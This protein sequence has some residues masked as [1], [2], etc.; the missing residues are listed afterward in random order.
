M[1]TNPTERPLALCSTDSKFACSA[2]ADQKAAPVV[3]SRRARRGLAARLLPMLV[4]GALS[5]VALLS[6]APAFAQSKIAIVDV[7]RA[8]LE[9]EEGLRVQ[10]TLKKLFD[11]RQVELETKERAL[12]AEKQKLDKEMQPG[13]PPSDALQRRIEAWQRQVAELQ[14]TTLEYQREM[15]RQESEMIMPLQR[16][17]QKVLWELATKEGYDLILDRAAAPYYRADLDLTDRAIQMYNS[18]HGKGGTPP[19]GAPAAPA[20]PA[21]KAPPPPAKK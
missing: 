10:A 1:Q 18:G 19:K 2:D 13:K 16:D 21:P 3:G 20:K 11:N 17:V 6:A 12:A 15:Q 14:A 5:G 8:M 4:A 7:R 9:T